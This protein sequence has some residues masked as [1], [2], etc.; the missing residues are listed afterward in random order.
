MSPYSKL[1]I[2]LA[3]AFEERAAALAIKESLEAAGAV[4]ISTWLTPDDNL[5]MNAL[6]KNEDTMHHECFTRA[7]KDREEIQRA[8]VFVLYKPKAIHKVPTTGGHHTEVGIALGAGKPI[9][10]I[11]AREN[12]FH[13]LPEVT[14][15]PDVQ[16]LIRALHLNGRGRNVLS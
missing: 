14:V 6:A 7:A 1:E 9:F 15:V 4:V 11:G 8:H 12:V 2:Y 3:T 5:S 10:I 13:Y 16:S